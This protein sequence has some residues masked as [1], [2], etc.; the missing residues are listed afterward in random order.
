[1]SMQPL[2]DEKALVLEDCLIVADLH[3]GLEKELA[4]AGARVPSQLTKMENRIKGLL[5]KTNK[6]RLV[7]LGDLKHNIPTA[8]WQEQREIPRLV[9]RLTSKAEVVLVKGNHDGGIENLVPELRVVRELRVGDT[10]LIH[11]HSKPVATGYET[12]IMAHNHPCIEFRGHLGGRLTESAWIRTRLREEHRGESDPEIVIM[13]AF[14]DLIYGMPFNSRKSQELLGPFF[15][16]GLVDLEGAKVY[17]IDG[18]Y[19]GKIK[20]LRQTPKQESPQ[21]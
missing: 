2:I 10:L 8:S 5:S 14:N 13:P 19:L 1:M 9:R 18:T 11:G 16:R 7:I 12:L 17:L 6:K 20:D 4:L 21:G 15:R 3:M